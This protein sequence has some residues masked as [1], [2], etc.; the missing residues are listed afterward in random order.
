MSLQQAA[1]ESCLN[2]LTYYHGPVRGSKAAIERSPLLPLGRCTFQR[3]Q[4]RDKVLGRRKSID[5]AARDRLRL[6]LRLR[7]LLVVAT[8]A[9]VY[10]VGWDD[11]SYMH[12]W[13]GRLGCVAVR[14]RGGEGRCT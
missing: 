10:P 12:D 3:M 8:V 4:G 11:V 5:S 13:V 1:L 2:G 14:Q 7:L 6:R 9:R